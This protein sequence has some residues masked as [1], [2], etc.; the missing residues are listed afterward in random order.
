MWQKV[1][2]NVSPYAYRDIKNSKISQNFENFPRFP[3]F[4]RHFW[5]QMN[6][7]NASG[8]PKNMRKR[9]KSDRFLRIAQNRANIEFPRTKPSLVRAF[10]DPP[11][12]PWIDFW[13]AILCSNGFHQTVISVNLSKTPQ[14]PGFGWTFQGN[15]EKWISLADRADLRQKVQRDSIRKSC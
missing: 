3:G 1:T 12:G 10:S 9:P 15:A 6:Y 5:A 14:K 7:Q 4:G 13:I 8:H 11:R 2:K